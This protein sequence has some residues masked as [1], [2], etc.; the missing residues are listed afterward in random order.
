VD[1]APF[2][3]RCL[4]SNEAV[5]VVGVEVMTDSRRLD[6]ASLGTPDPDGDERKLLNLIPISHLSDLFWIWI[7]RGQEQHWK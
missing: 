5:T 6:L 4:N 1:Y 2:G 3:R 7:Q